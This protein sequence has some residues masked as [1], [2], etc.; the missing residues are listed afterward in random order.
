MAELLG[1]ASW[2]HQFGN[3]CAPYVVPNFHRYEQQSTSTLTKNFLNHGELSITLTTREPAPVCRRT[4]NVI[5][6]L[7]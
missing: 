2:S 6:F 4:R 5:R 7:P 1:P 3:A